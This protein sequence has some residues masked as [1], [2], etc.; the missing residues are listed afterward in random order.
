MLRDCQRMKHQATN[1]TDNSV[2]VSENL[3]A[4]RANEGYDLYV[5]RLS[6]RNITQL[7]LQHNAVA[8]YSGGSEWNEWVSVQGDLS[9]CC[10]YC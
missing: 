4:S 6:Y 3:A 2:D 7:Y 10:N 8:I 1:T 5:E 9:I